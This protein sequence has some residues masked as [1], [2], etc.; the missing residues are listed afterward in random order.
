[1]ANY[2][3]REKKGSQVKIAN[4]VISN[5]ACMAA[6][7]VKGV[8]FLSDNVITN[9]IIGRFGIKNLAKGIKIEIDDNCVFCEMSICIEYGYSIPEVSSRVQ[10]RVATAI[11]DMTGLKVEEVNV[12]IVG[13]NTPKA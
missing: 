1:M 10:E 9:E 12:H 5:I 2:T 3:G 13:I 8:A 7:E 4:D 11:N 6:A